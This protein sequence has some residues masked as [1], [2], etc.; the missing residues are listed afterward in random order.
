MDK[1][2]YEQLGFINDCLVMQ[3]SSEQGETCFTT[4]YPAGPS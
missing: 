3:S 4:T 1:V 2:T